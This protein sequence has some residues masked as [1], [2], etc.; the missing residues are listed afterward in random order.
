[1]RPD[2]S[3]PEARRERA[4]ARKRWMADG[5]AEESGPRPET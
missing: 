5:L 3:E 1:M 2:G 4:S